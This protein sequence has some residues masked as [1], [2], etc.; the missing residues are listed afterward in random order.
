MVKVLFDDGMQ[1]TLDTAAAFH[2]TPPELMPSKWREG[3]ID[4][5]CRFG[6]AT[7]RFIGPSSVAWSK[8]LATVWLLNV[9]ILRSFGWSSESAA[10]ARNDEPAACGGTNLVSGQEPPG[11]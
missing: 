1:L 6:R 2:T 3:C 7:T 5:E 4:G 8:D 9:F 10:T 11:T